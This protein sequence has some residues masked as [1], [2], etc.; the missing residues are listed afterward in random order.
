MDQPGLLVVVR[1]GAT[2]RFRLLQETFAQESL[3]VLWDRRGAVR[4]R[5]QQPVATERRRHDRRRQPDVWTGDGFI[6][7]STRTLAAGT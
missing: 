6:I 2:E 4:R 3:T 5:A 1:R 7:V